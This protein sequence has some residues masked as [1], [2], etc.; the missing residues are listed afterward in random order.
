MALYGQFFL[1][2]VLGSTVHSPL[3]YGICLKVSSTK[4]KYS[5]LTL[6]LSGA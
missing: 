6:E 2:K 4:N 3:P 1:K 5:K